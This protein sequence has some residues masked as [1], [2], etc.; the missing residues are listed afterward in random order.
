MEDSLEVLSLELELELE[1]EPVAAAI[2]LVTVG[3]SVVAAVSSVF[4][5]KVELLVST[6]V[7]SKREVRVSL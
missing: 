1:L 2:A 6:T 7:D 3:V 5:T 4:V